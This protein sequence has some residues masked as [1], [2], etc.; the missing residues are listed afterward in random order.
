MAV[1]ILGLLGLG[2]YMEDF[3]DKESENRMMIY[4]IHKSFGALVLILFFVRVVNRFIN[5]PPTLPETL[6]K[7]ERIG[8]HIGH[9]ALYFLM[10]AMPLSGYLMS[11]SYGYPVKL[12]GL[13][14]PFLIGKNF[15]SGKIFASAHS[16]FGYALIAVV[17]IHI[18]AVIKHKF[19]DQ[20]END[21]LKRMI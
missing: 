1:I 14:L 6:Q 12:F 4:S 21:V 16:Y 17:L 19:F 7:I 2:I 10:L 11:N 13:Q 20:K 8:A 15:E 3:L 9:I 5:K 18:A